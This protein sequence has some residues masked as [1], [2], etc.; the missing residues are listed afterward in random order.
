MHQFLL[1][2]CG[3][4]ASGK[5]TLAKTLAA[6]L[7]AEVDVE[8]V[9]TDKWRDAT[10]YEDFKPEK[11]RMVR[12]EALRR[13]KSILAEGKSVIHDDTNYYTSMRHE[14]FEIAEKQEVSF[15]ILYL[16]TPIDV[17]LVWNKDREYEIPV[18]VI[19]KINERLDIPG[20]KYAWDR[21]M[22]SIDLS[23]IDVETAVDKIVSRVR[24]LT[25]I[26]ID[27]IETSQTVAE[28]RDIRTRQV[29][30]EFL[31]ENEKFQS[32]QIVHQIRAEILRDA[33]REELSVDATVEMLW[34]KLRNLAKR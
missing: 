28:E 25:S 4:P 24:N 17:C 13:T 12:E 32:E 6:S 7:T 34:K 29:I 18:E 1:I 16:S 14:L 19:K 23:V 9:S 3:L 2:T 5:T 26:R 11:E 21:E 30:S 33:N 8:V 10:Y 15:G 20:S 22:I 31:N 27:R